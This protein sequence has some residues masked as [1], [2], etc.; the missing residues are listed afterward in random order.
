MKAVKC[1]CCGEIPTFT[2][3]ETGNGRRWEALCEHCRESTAPCDNLTEAIK[4]WTV[5][6]AETRRIMKLGIFLTQYEF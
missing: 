5:L 2:S 6:Q 4:A 3:N 1:A